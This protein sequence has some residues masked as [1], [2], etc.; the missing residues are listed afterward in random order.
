M[1]I[2]FKG[3]VPVQLTVSFRSSFVKHDA[4]RVMAALETAGESGRGNSFPTPFFNYD[5]GYSTIGCR[6]S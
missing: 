4:C 3:A 1:H 2:L 6:V 5:Q